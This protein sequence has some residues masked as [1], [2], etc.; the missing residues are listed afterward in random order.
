MG[1]VRSETPCPCCGVSDPCECS[2]VADWS[3]MI[4]VLHVLTSEA[5]W[6]IE[7]Y[8][9]ADCSVPSG[10]TTTSSNVDSTHM[11][12]EYAGSD[13]SFVSWRLIGMRSCV[14]AGLGNRCVDPEEVEATGPCFDLSFDEEIRLR[15]GCD[16]QRW[17]MKDAHPNNVWYPVEVSGGL[18]VIV[19]TGEICDS[20][21]SE[22]FTACG[23]GVLDGVMVESAG[24]TFGSGRTD[25]RTLCTRV[26]I[27]IIP[28]VPP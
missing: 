5:F 27:D 8:A 3:Q 12:F 22:I 18:K 2:G 21:D 20:T 28:I 19:D 11:T 13:G 24:S 26:V 15:W 23:G 17:E 1:T 10:E 25:G 14:V 16:S 6:E 4:V 7:D 9:H